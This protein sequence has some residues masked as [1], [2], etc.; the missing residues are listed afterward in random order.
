METRSFK[1]ALLGA[2]LLLSGA[3]LQSA[4]AAPVFASTNYSADVVFSDAAALQ[5]TRMTISFD[6]TSYFSASGG[7]NG[8]TRVAQFSADGSLVDTYSPGLDLRSVF[9]NGS[10]EV[11]A[12]P[13]ADS[14]IYKQT[15]PGSF[16]A[17]VTFT[18]NPLDDQSAVVM[19]KSGQFVAMQGG[20]VSLWNASGQALSTFSLNGFGSQ[21][22]ENGYPANR[23]I[24]AVGDHLFTYSAG[25]VSAWD[26]SGQRVDTAVLDGA[27]TSFDSYFSFSYANGRFFVLDDAN[28]SWRGYDAGLGSDVAPVPLP[29][30]VLLMGGALVG[31]ALRRRGPIRH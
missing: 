21:N 17:L 27:G 29:S 13:Y 5:Q 23:G 1:P 31:L 4:E 19:N 14:T 8:G 3:A 18:G 24:A 9:T 12:R 2:L 15:S 16:S 30:S 11:L 26:Y 22:D 20:L 25:T 6:G 28:G 10:H 7:G